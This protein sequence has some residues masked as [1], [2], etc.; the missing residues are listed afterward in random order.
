M[1]AGHRPHRGTTGY[2]IRLRTRGGMDGIAPHSGEHHV[3]PP[4]RPTAKHDA[5]YA[6]GFQ[7]DKYPPRP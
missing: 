3:Q 2:D 1:F 7:L 4:S 5:M 6:R